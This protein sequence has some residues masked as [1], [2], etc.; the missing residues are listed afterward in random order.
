[1][2]KRLPLIT[3]IKIMLKNTTEYQPDWEFYYSDKHDN[4][5]SFLYKNKQDILLLGCKFFES[6][7]IDLVTQKTKCLDKFSRV[8]PKY[9]FN[10]QDANLR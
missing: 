8:G 10:P 7:F 9:I 6:V 2:N 5:K 3:S 4:I 1:M